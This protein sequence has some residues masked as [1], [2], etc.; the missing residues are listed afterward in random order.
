M[1]NL[2]VSRIRDEVARLCQES[3]F[4]LSEEMMSALEKAREREESPAGREVI[5]QIQENADIASSEEIPMCQDTGTT[6]V[7]A[8]VGQ[9]IELVGGSLEKAINEGVRKG[10]EEGYLRKSIVEDPARKRENTGDNTP[11]IIHTRL[12][13]GDKIKLTVAPKGGGSE[14]M[15]RLKMLTPAD[16]E[17]G[18]KD[19]V[20]NAVVE[21]GPNPCP[22]VIVGVGVGG[23]FEK[24]ALLAKEA[25]MEPIDSDKRESDMPELEEA[26]LE[27]INDSGVGPQGFGG[28]ITAL[29]VNI[30]TYPCHIASLPVAVNINCHAARHNSVTI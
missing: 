9:D 12:V 29:G 11:A 16:G 2:E 26:I 15:S 14:N 4:Y 10:Y 18:V 8:E 22:P 3:N 19:F 21:A 20:V 23:N 30:K 6:V 1:R 5:E 27:E 7:F 24:A 17:E 25:L 13:E 28:R